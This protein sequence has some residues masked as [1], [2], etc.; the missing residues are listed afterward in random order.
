MV[1]STLKIKPTNDIEGVKRWDILCFNGNNAFSENW[2]IFEF[3]D[4][5]SSWRLWELRIWE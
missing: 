1:I 2:V 5:I 4:Q 3:C